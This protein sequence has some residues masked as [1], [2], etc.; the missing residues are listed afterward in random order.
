MAQDMGLKESEKLCISVEL[1]W[2]SLNH[3]T[4]PRAR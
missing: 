3:V 4:S 2:G 1:E